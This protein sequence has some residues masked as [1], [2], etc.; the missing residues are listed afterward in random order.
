[1]TPTPASV[2]YP[3]LP[4]PL[5]PGDLQQLFSPSFDE[6]QWAPT[7][8]RT[9]DSQV[10]LLVRPRCFPTIHRRGD[11]LAEK[12]VFSVV[13]R[14]PAYCKLPSDFQRAGL[15]RTQLDD[16]CM[17]ELLWMLG[18]RRA[19][20]HALAYSW[21]Q[22]FN[23]ALQCSPAWISQCPYGGRNTPIMLKKVF[24]GHLLL[25]VRIFPL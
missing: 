16:G 14:R 15:A 4:D 10:A 12:L 1:M 6:R 20:N 3:E 2:I 17:L 13:K 5:T 11:L 21:L 23:P 24:N 22:F 25:L 19:P 18:I 7:V 8:S 9:V